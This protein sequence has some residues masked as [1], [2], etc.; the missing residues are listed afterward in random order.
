MKAFERI[1]LYSILAVLVF[2][3][4]LVD[5]N[6]ESKVAIQEK[7]YARR[8]VIVN[9]AGQEIVWLFAN[10]DGNGVIG[11]CNKDGT[12]TAGIGASESGG[13]MEIYNDEG[14]KVVV[15]CADSRTEGGGRVDI[16]NGDGTS[17]AFMSA[18]RLWAYEDGGGITVYNKDGNIVASMRAIS[19]GGGI[20][21]LNKDGNI[22]ADIGACKDGGEVVVCNKH[23]EVI[24]NLP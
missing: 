18:V 20:T 21:F 7:I 5:G 2:Y 6:V 22:V 13:T 3:V 12:T 9:D 14:Q 1:F 8:I 24:G 15:L 4:F 11:V 16:F 17:G 23:G 19:S 10:K